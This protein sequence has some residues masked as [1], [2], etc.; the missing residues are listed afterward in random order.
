[1][2]RF[3]RAG[4]IGGLSLRHGIVAPILRWRSD[5]VN[6]TK[7]FQNGKN[8]SQKMLAAFSGF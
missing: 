1:M 4:K 2:A 3:T 6:N 7:R 8:S 5:A